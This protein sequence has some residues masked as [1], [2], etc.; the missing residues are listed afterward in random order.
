MIFETFASECSLFFG[1]QMCV[2]FAATPVFPRKSHANSCDKVNFSVQIITRPHC[3]VFL[4]LLLLMADLQQPPVQRGLCLPQSSRRHHGKPGPGA[5][6]CFSS[7]NGTSGLQTPRVLPSRV[8]PS[9]AGF[10]QP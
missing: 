1:G 8:P 7:G 5:M 6:H 3:Y 4:M 2:D 9:K 10:L